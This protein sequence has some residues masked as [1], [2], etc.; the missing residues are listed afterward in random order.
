MTSASI[1][2]PT[3]DL[4]KRARAPYDGPFPF[5]TGHP[6][7]VMLPLPQI[8]PTPKGAGSPSRA[9]G[10]ASQPPERTEYQS[11][12][13]RKTLLALSFLLLAPFFASL[14]IMLYQRVSQGIW[15][16]VAG[17]VVMLMGFAAIMM[18]LLLELVSALRAEVSIGERTVEFTLPRRSGGLLPGLRFRTHDIAYT[19]IAE[20]EERREIYGERFAPVFMRGIRLILKDGTQI[21]LGYVNEANVDPTF[22][23][24]EIGRQI[25][26]RAGLEVVD[27][28]NVRRSVAHKLRILTL[29]GGPLSADDIDRIN[30]RHDRMMIGLAATLGLLAAAGIGF[31]LWTGSIDRGERGRDAVTQAAPATKNPPGAARAR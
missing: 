10:A 23:F 12:G 19:D 1:A 25:A 22:P 6:R 4:L 9:K 18:L 14:P 29:T 26:V 20:I 30:A 3:G 8:T 31:D 5:P 21:P 2:G 17:L 27:R 28:G 24:P 7:D 11:N 13:L 16:D 15:L